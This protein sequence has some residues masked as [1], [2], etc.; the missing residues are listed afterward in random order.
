MP[1]RIICISVFAFR[2]ELQH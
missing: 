2:A 1:K